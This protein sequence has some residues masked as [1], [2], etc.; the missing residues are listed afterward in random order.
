MELTMRFYEFGTNIQE[1][2]LDTVKGWFSGGSS[3][4]LTNL[5]VPS[6]TRGP[7]V[8]DL[9]K[10]LV[11]LGFPLPRFGIDGIRGP[12]TNAAISQFQSANGLPSTSEPDQKTI[13][14]LNA[15][16][17]S[18]PDIASKLTKS[19]EADVKSARAVEFTGKGDASKGI[20]LS[21]SAR[22]AIEFFMSKGWTLEQAAGIVGNLQTESGGGLNINAVGDGGRAYG[23]AQ[24]H[25]DR[26]AQFA[27][28]MKKNIRQSNLDDQLAFVQWEL[29][30]SESRAGN[31]LRG[32]QSTE[33]AALT[34][35]KY[36]ER[37]AGLHG[38]HRVNNALALVNAVSKSNTL[39]IA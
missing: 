22:H 3:E 14:K 38:A 17:K 19:T 27:R 32:A 34:F 18:K 21:N 10:V 16:L 36:Y 39:N 13:E 30:N 28:T 33:Q 6:S 23:I 4:P 8:A 11:A 26:Q 12:E 5:T 2:I 31:A 20:G 24:W 25:P 15:I 29:E 37:S 9:Q 7:E 35:D 1:G